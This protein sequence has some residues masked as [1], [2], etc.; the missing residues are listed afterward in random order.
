MSSF[1]SSGEACGY[2][3]L[4]RIWLW[5]L[6]SSFKK[7]KDDSIFMSKRSKVASCHKECNKRAES[8]GTCRLPIGPTN[9][10]RKFRSMYRFRS[11]RP[12]EPIGQP[13]FQTSVPGDA[14][15]F[16]ERCS[17]QYLTLRNIPYLLHSRVV[18]TATTWM[19][20]MH[21]STSCH[22]ALI[23]HLSSTETHHP[24]LPK[25]QCHPW[26]LEEGLLTTLL[27]SQV[28]QACALMLSEHVVFPSPPVESPPDLVLGLGLGQRHR[29]ATAKA[30]PLLRLISA[31]NDRRTFSCCNE[32]QSL[33]LH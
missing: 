15:I 23:A 32:R 28:E 5:S 9:F 16:S 12:E 1:A 29:S 2:R 26:L 11:N 22:G 30:Q 20:N 25:S 31:H 18:T 10:D 7:L 24:I 17:W 4:V 19:C 33:V 27:A 8:A 3:T 13:T 14:K 6:E 21:L